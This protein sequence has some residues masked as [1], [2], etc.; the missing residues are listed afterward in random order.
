MTLVKF[1]RKPFE[2]S[3]NNLFDDFFNDFPVLYK[4]EK[5]ENGWKGF[6]PVNIK[7]TEKNYSLEVVAPGFEK[8]DFNVNLDQ[9]ILTISAEKKN[10][11]KDENEKQVRKEY[12]YRSFNRSFTIDEQIDSNNIEANYVNGVLTLNLPKKVAVKAPVT[13]IKIK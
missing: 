2:Q 1:N 10:E 7:E 4:D 9:N 8:A 5:N 12:S 3:F 6:I 11:I 13:E